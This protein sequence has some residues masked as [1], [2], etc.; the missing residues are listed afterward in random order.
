MDNRKTMQT[1]LDYI[2]ENLKAE[3][4]VSDL[5]DMTGYSLYHFYRLFQAAVGMPVMQYILRRKL[6]NAIYDIS[7][8]MSMI[9]AALLYG[10]E[11]YAGFYKAFRREIGYT[12][13]DF[14]K[15][16]KVKKP[17]KINLFKEEHIMLTH[18]KITEILKHWDLQ[19]ESIKDIY[20]EGTGERHDN[21]YYIGDKYVVKATANLGDL[22]KQISLTDAISSAGLYAANVVKT[23]NN[24]EYI[25]DGEYYFIL[26]ERLDGSQIKPNKVYSDGYA[27]NARFIGEIIGQLHLA[28]KNVDAVVNDVDIFSD[29]IN[30]AMPKVKECIGMSDDLCREY[31]VNFGELYPTLPKQIIHRDPNPS[32][33]ITCDDKWGFIDFE[34]SEKNVRIFDPCYAAT[35]ILSET[36]AEDDKNKLEKW[37]GIY[38]EII[39]GY[40]SVVKLSD[41]E[42]KA[43]PYVLLSNQLIA[44]AW[45][46]E[47]EKYKDF[48]EVN[49]K[50]TRWIADNF[51]RLRF[52]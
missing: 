46:A 40:D 33:I 19:N 31:T 47:Q 34:L 12:P 51:S 4:P 18:K 6:L 9:E 45:F 8:G 41:D 1:A 7:N 14:L 13:S 21:A 5:S 44:T 37:I 11:T 49:I 22:K 32:N 39:I 38:K 17:Y 29:V 52:D 43:V 25:S 3:I 42:L 10:F 48:Y 30:W 28:L 16:F 26:T 15:R 50:M 23:L 20:Y 35:A 27:S 24:E 2:E 36:F